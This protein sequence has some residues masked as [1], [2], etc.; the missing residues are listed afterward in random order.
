[1]IQD[2]ETIRPTIT[3]VLQWV[4]GKRELL[5]ELRKVYN[6]LN[7]NNYYELFVGGGSVYLD[8]FNVLGGG[9]NFKSVLNKCNIIY[10]V[11]T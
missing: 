5:P 1:M 2:I 4:G 10:V 8:L 6:G 3:P 11:L 7:F 9:F